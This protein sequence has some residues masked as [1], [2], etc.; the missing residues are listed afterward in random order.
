MESVDQKDEQYLGYQFNGGDLKEIL[1]V[2]QKH[3]SFNNQTLKYFF[4]TN[5]HLILKKLFL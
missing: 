2:M 1:P 5:N 4:V 3:F